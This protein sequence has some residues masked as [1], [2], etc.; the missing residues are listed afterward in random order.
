MSRLY[1]LPRM[2]VAGRRVGLADRVGGRVSLKEGT[3]VL[4]PEHWW[5]LKG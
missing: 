4:A 3:L 1:W 2:F 5:D